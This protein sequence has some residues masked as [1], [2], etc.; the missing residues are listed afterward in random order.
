[1]FLCK[2]KL[3]KRIMREGEGELY[4]EWYWCNSLSFLSSFF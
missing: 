2:R 4:W 1:M 3:E